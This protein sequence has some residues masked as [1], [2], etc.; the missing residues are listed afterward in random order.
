MGQFYWRVSA[1][2][3]EG[4]PGNNSV[5]RSFLIIADTEPP[6][7]LLGSPRQDTI[8]R[9]STIDVS[10]STEPEIVLTIKG[11]TVPISAEGRF[12]HKLSLHSGMNE[13]KVVV[14]DRAGNITEK[15][16]VINYVSDEAYSIAYDAGLITK[17]P[18]HFMAVNNGFTLSGVTEPASTVKVTSAS[19]TVRSRSIANQSGE[20][21]MNLMLRE[22]LT[23]LYI[24]TKSKT[25]TAK[26]DTIKIE[27][28][29][30]PPVI[31]LDRA[32]ESSTAIKLL[33]L[34]G[35]VDGGASL[36]LNGKSIEIQG[37]RFEKEIALK[38]GSNSLK[39]EA[40]DLV[41]NVS[42]FEKDV[43]FD[44]DPP[45]YVRHSLSMG[46]VMGGE[47][48][49]ITLSASDVSGLKETCTYRLN[50]AGQDY[51]GYL[52]YTKADKKFKGMFQVPPGVKG[53]IG[54]VEFEVA[55]R[56]G[57]AVVLKP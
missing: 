37:S 4:I 9:S 14:T 40:T 41:E 26:R 32:L 10:G 56:L 53:A 6:F 38:P 21:Q 50:I 31:R 55:D 39:L 33:T 46:T 49:E 30:Q 19:R 25:G 34:A 11:E 48:V 13:V 12:T 54:G 52:K 3:S 2:S 24:E 17:S 47:Q 45:K 23:T 22:D 28:D 20:F 36:K 1:V 7:L 5:N 18:K 27:I 8:S 29:D 16:I 42:Y 57:N 51:N 43:Y 15:G 35:S 44:P